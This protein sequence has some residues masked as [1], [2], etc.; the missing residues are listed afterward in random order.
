MT[1]EKQ[2]MSDEFP[3]GAEMLGVESF[4]ATRRCVE[5]HLQSHL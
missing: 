3:T 1:H 4:P 2:N 5:K